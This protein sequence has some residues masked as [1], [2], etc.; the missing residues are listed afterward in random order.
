MK[1]RKVRKECHCV[2]CGAKI[3]PEIRINGGPWTGGEDIYVIRGGKG[4]GHIY[5]HPACYAREPK[6]GD[7]ARARA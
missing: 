1:T 3:E 6:H 7:V 4:N 2:I 5:V